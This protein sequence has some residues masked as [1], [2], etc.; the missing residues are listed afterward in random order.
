MSDT[1]VWFVKPFQ[2]LSWPGFPILLFIILG[3]NRTVNSIKAKTNINADKLSFI[4]LTVD[5]T[6]LINILINYRFRLFRWTVWR[7]STINSWLGLPRPVSNLFQ[8]LSV[9][10]SIAS[11]ASIFQVFMLLLWILFRSPA[12]VEILEGIVRFRANVPR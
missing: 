3:E 7:A 6:N 12:A 4:Y 1:K 11:I 2:I 5:N 9:L 10:S 8:I